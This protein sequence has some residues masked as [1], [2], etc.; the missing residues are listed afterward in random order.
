[1]KNKSVS[2]SFMQWLLIIVLK[3]RVIILLHPSSFLKLMAYVE[4][5]LSVNK[6]DACYTYAVVCR[7]MTNKNKCNYNE[8]YIFIPLFQENCSRFKG[9]YRVFIKYCVYSEFIKKILDSVFPRCQCVYT[10][11]AGR[12]P[13]LKQNWQSS[14]KS[15]NFKEVLVRTKNV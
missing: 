11:Q 1:M 12:K 3:K 15:Q 8:I 14:E 10:H 6:S 7:F 2:Y 4:Y 5:K 13:A 9:T